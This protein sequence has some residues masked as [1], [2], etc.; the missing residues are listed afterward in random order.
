MN[1]PETNLP[2]EYYLQRGL[3][4]IAETQDETIKINEFILQRRNDGRDVCLHASVSS[5]Q[6]PESFKATHGSTAGSLP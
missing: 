4:F 6:F 3:H 1:H 5:L 2:A